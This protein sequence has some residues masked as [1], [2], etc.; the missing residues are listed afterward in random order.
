MGDGQLVRPN[1]H[2]AVLDF[3]SFISPGLCC[4]RA[5]LGF[6]GGGNAECCLCRDTHT[7]HGAGNSASTMRRHRERLNSESEIHHLQFD[8]SEV[9]SSLL[10]CVSFRGGFEKGSTI[11]IKR[12]HAGFA[13]AGFACTCRHQNIQLTAHT[14]AFHH[15]DS[16]LVWQGCS[17]AKTAESIQYLAHSHR[18]MIT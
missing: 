15:S 11:I 8:R 17:S 10:V 13:H 9:P 3:S 16:S 6:R 4:F 18:G 1:R 2:T 14:T 12:A 5:H 7:P